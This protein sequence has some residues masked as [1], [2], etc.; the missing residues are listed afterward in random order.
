METIISTNNN[1]TTT[2]TTEQLAE[3]IVHPSI[4]DIL[5]AYCNLYSLGTL[6]RTHFKKYLKAH[7]VNSE[8]NPVVLQ[9]KKVLEQNTEFRSSPLLKSLRLRINNNSKKSVRY[10]PYKRTLVGEH[11]SLQEEP[12]V[13]PLKRA[14][15]FEIKHDGRTIQLSD[16]PPNVPVSLHFNFYE[17]NPTIKP[18]PNPSLGKIK[19]DAVLPDDSKA[20]VHMSPTS[21][22]ADLRF[23]LRSVFLNRHLEVLP[24]TIFLDTFVL[25]TRGNWTLNLSETV[26]D[27]VNPGSVIFC[28]L[29]ERPNPLY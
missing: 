12:V 10:N 24:E 16:L 6:D 11:S 14:P 8:I 28:Y 15:S 22:V 25:K 23:E 19:V 26:A 1:T 5:R 27:V 2:T 4:D 21:T 7:K 18:Q 20:T 9:L 13:P 3:E 29:H 17:N